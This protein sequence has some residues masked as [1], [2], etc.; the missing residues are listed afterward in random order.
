[1]ISLSKLLDWYGGDF[2]KD[3]KERIEWIKKYLSADA[4]VVFVGDSFGV[5]LEPRLL[6]LSPSTP[7]PVVMSLIPLAVSA[8]LFLS[9]FPG[10]GFVVYLQCLLRYFEELIHRLT[11]I[12]AL[13]GEQQ[14][15]A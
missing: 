2:A 15:N 8:S 6:S 12:N 13:V 10:K 4:Y 3:D 5:L 7:F 1:M 11:I 9:F 14:T